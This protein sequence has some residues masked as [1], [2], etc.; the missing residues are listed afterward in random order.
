VDENSAVPE[1]IDALSDD[2]KANSGLHKFQTPEDIAKSYLE[3]E[4]RVG[5]SLRIPGEDAGMDAHKDFAEKLR[6]KY[7][8]VSPYKLGYLPDET[9]ESRQLY[10]QQ[11]GV[12]AEAK[13]YPDAELDEN[14]M[15][16]S[17]DMAHFMEA[18]PAQ[19][20]KM[21]QWME[22][23]AAEVKEQLDAAESDR[24]G[25]IREQL[26]ESTEQRISRIESVARGKG[27]E[28]SLEGAPPPVVLLLDSLL[29][30]I[31]GQGPQGNGVASVEVGPSTSDLKARI[32]E[33]RNRLIKERNTLPRAEYVRLQEANLRDMETLQKSQ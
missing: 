4:G 5:G 23:E 1:W 15:N 16:R 33:R 24:I 21:A 20:K 6:N 2:L 22:K 8:E 31:Q 30:D 12:P 28:L 19:Y 11:R 17:K 13:E 18:D 32:A 27:L 3:L 10:N 25:A 29:D 26:G 7:N 9:E 14:L